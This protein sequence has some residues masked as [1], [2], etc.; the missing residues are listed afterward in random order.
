MSLDVQALSQSAI[1]QRTALLP[2]SQ[3]AAP[4]SQGVN[5]TTYCLASTTVVCLLVIAYITECAC[6]GGIEAADPIGAFPVR[7]NRAYQAMRRAWNVLW[8]SKGDAGCLSRAY[9]LQRWA[10]DVFVCHAGEDKA[11]ARLLRERML[12]LTFRCFVDEDSLRVGER[13]PQAMQAAVRSTQIAVVLLC[14][15]FFQKE[16]PQRELRW[17]LEGGRQSRIVVVPVFLGIT[18]ERCQELAGLAELE[19]VC[20]YTGVRHASERRRFTGVPVHEEE[21]MLR[22]IQSV[23]AITG[24]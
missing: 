12:P 13:A 15:E 18:V 9:Q 20:E 10:W 4:L 21:T 1:E 2:D 6:A 16:A 5:C 14:E 23:R 3:Q 24:L 7:H 22:V 11:F 8:P 17:F 19:G